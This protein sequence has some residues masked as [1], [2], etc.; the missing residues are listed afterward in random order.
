MGGGGLSPA[1]AADGSEG[2]CCLWVSRDW[3]WRRE[4][5]SQADNMAAGSVPR[6]LLHVFTLNCLVPATQTRL[7]LRLTGTCTSAGKTRTKSNSWWKIYFNKTF[8]DRGDD[9]QAIDGCF[10]QSCSDCDD[11]ATQF[12][13][14][15][16]CPCH[17]TSSQ[18]L[19]LCSLASAVPRFLILDFIILDTWPLDIQEG[20][21]LTTP[22]P[23]TPL[24]III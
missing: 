11:T 12:K 21:S 2:R 22:V 15:C 4:E 24:N 13:P 19:A 7:H 9:W 18:R 23:T 3:G 6:L 14:T 10:K 17:Q 1:S 8:E 16:W 20:G 5:R